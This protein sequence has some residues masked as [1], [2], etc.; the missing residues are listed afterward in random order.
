[1][2]QQPVREAITD[3]KGY[4]DRRY[5]EG[6]MQDF[7]DLFEACRLVTVRQILAAM[8]T[9][10]VKPKSVLDYG[11]G[12]GRYIGILREFFPEATVSGCD[13]SD[14]GLSIAREFHPD[15]QLIPML[16]ET[17]HAPG[18][19]FDLVISI[20]VLEHVRDVRRAALEIARVLKPAGTLLL[21]TPCANPYSLEWVINRLRGGLEPSFDGF[22]RFA[23]DEPGHLRRLNDSQLREIFSRHGVTFSTILHRAHFFTTVMERLDRRLAFL[24][25]TWR[26]WTAMLDWDL[27]RMLP[28]GATMIAVGEKRNEPDA[29]G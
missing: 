15:V 9:R 3:P 4:Y 8:R 21:T 28:N 20:E 26:L 24:P 14:A 29:V 16:D 6:Y 12:E 23:T 1:M 7:G 13:I 25:K 19:V 18:E 10:G 11:C 22:G 17:V 2:P 27:L 5:R